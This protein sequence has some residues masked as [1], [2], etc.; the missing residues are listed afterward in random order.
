M[1]NDSFATGLRRAAQ[2]MSGWHVMME[3]GHDDDAQRCAFTGKCPNQ[4]GGHHEKWPTFIANKKP[5]V[6]DRN[7]SRKRIAL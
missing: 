3:Y 6:I 1:P 7:G 2:C 4:V 5:M